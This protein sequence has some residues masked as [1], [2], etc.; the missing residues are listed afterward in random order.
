MWLLLDCPAMQ[1]A[2]LERAALIGA[3]V[4][5][6]LVGV[7]VVR[8][9]RMAREPKPPDLV[10]ITVDTLR[11]DRIGAY[12]YSAA[13][14]PTVDRLAE[15]GVLFWQATT[16]FPRTTPALASL[17]TGL[18]P[19]HHGSREVQQTVARGKRLV[20]LL[21]E[22]SYVSIGVTANSA[23]GSQV[24]LHHGFSRFADQRDLPAPVAEEVT[25]RA[26][27]FL[28]EVDPGRPLFL[29]VHYNDPHWPYDPPATWVTLPDVN[30]C[31]QLRW[32][33]LPH[34]LLFGN[35]GGLAAA[36]LE[37]CGRLYDAEIAYTD[38]QIGRLLDGLEAA[39]RLDNALVVT[40]SDHGENLGEAGLFYE[41]GPSVHDASLR[42]P[43]IISG[44]GVAKARVDGDVARLEDLMPTLL[45]L[46]EFPTAQW[47][48]MDGLDLSARLRSGGDGSQPKAN[49]TAALAESGSALFPRQFDLLVSG[50][51]GGRHC[52]H[53]ARYSL[54]RHR[55]YQAVFDHVA[56][57]WLRQQIDDPEGEIAAPLE[58][59]SRRWSVEGA[60]ERTARTP[61]F[62]L[63]EYPSAEGGYHRALY[64]LRA[65]PAESRD[66]AAH[67]PEVAQRL[68][69]QLEDWTREL[70]T[71]VP[72]DRSEE[73]L[74][75][76][77]ALGYIGD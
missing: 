50:R 12:G 70:P 65:D 22:R 55:G 6:V 63:V 17:H 74:E 33:D 30:A 34:G 39:G 26:L 75:E 47:P 5:T 28:G 14:T 73:D 45:A 29:W 51:K 71:F 44:P 77:R 27:A 11:A 7:A 24:G 58:E 8:A 59:Q 36:A 41:H 1:R 61:E 54:C 76:L 38:S 2:M 62:K 16:P 46:L 21:N 15:G 10:L 19:H 3:M 48:P 31:S 35:H 40:T 32:R 9:F 53:G 52:F 25:R 43:L 72:P 18:W 60:R 49:G 68:A 67:H 57:P 23:A 64:D 20:Q 37:D 66:V 69:R 42:V 4:A 56:D 13:R